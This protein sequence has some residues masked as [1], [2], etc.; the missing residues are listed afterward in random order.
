MTDPVVADIEAEAARQRASGRVPEHYEEDLDARFAALVP[1]P[2][3]RRPL[4]RSVARVGELA[5]IDRQVPVASRL[6]AGS[7]AK[8]LVRRAVGWY[9]R[10]FVDQVAEFAAAVA[11][12]LGQVEADLGDLRGAVPAETAPVTGAGTAASPAPGSSAG[13]VVPQEPGAAPWWWRLVAQAAKPAAT[14][15]SGPLVHGACGPGLLLASLVSTGVAAYGVDPDPDAVG[16]ATAGGADARVEDLV[17]HLAAV[18]PGT[19][20]AVV[21]EAVCETATPATCERLAELATRAVGPGGFVAVASRTPQAWSRSAPPVVAD[22]APGRPLHADTWAHLFARLGW[23]AVEIHRG[24]PDLVA[25]LGGATSE[26]ASAEPSAPSIGS[27]AL[28]ALVGG[29][30]EYLVVARRP[31]VPERPS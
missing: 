13:R 31:T 16:R 24:G 2:D 12:A 23:T 5:H 21:V 27:A 8:R 4:E 20:A 25:A 11:G 6:A 30:D 28:A 7:W 17:D 22:L 29:P 26:G 9:V 10:Y 14:A 3:P 1:V 18:A 19:L 15:P